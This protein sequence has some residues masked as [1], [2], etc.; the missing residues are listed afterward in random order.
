MSGAA[1]KLLGYLVWHV[2]RWYLRR[3][4]G[5][6]RRIVA[7]LLAISVAFGAAL[8]ARRRGG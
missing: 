6:R 5:V 3:R 1:Y 8:V 4:L 2:G 7:G